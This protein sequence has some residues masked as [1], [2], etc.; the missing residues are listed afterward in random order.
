MI[1][2]SEGDVGRHWAELVFIHAPQLF[3]SYICQLLLPVTILYFSVINRA[4][5]IKEGEVFARL[6]CVFQAKR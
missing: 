4:L 2:V 5:P 1:C 6:M 3:S